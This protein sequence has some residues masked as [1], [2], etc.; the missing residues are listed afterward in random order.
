MLLFVKGE[1]AG[2]GLVGNRAG[3]RTVVEIDQG[4]RFTESIIPDAIC[5]SR[6]A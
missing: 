6:G 1:R 2:V 3:F 4:S 5:Y